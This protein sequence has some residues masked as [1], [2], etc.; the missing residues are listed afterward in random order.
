[1]KQRLEDKLDGDANNQVAKSYQSFHCPV[2]G[3]LYYSGSERHFSSKRFLNQHIAKVHA[4]KKYTCL[5]CQKGFGDDWWRRYHEKSCGQVWKCSC[6]VQY[7]SRETL[8]TH[9]RRMRHELPANVQSSKQSSKRKKSNTISVQPVIVPVV[10]MISAPV[11]NQ[12]NYPTSQISNMNKSSSKLRPILPK[13]SSLQTVLTVPAVPSVESSELCINNSNQSKISDSIDSTRARCT[14]AARKSPS[15]FPCREGF[16]GS[17]DILGSATTTLNVGQS[18]CDRTATETQT[19]EDIP[20]LNL[21]DNI[22]S[23]KNKESRGSQCSG[24]IR[25]RSVRIESIETQTMESALNKIKR[26]S[27]L[28]RSRRKSVAITTDPEIPESVLSKNCNDAWNRHKY[29][30][31]TQTADE[32]SSCKVFCDMETI[33]DDLFSFDW[34]EKM[35]RETKCSTLD[36]VASLSS[37]SVDS[38][39]QNNGIDEIPILDMFSNADSLPFHAE[40]IPS[41]AS[42]IMAGQESCG[43]LQPQGEPV[44]SELST[45]FPSCLASGK[46]LADKAEIPPLSDIQ[47]QTVAP[48]DF[49]YS[50]ILSNME[51]QTTGDFFF[52]DLEFLDNETQTPWED[53]SNIEDSLPVDQLSI[54]IQTDFSSFSDAVNNDPYQLMME[55]QMQSILQN[56]ATK[57][58]EV[59]HTQTQTQSHMESPELT[60]SASQTLD[61]VTDLLFS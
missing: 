57:S 44:N 28:H 18:L 36:M 27:S 33:T 45:V 39:P 17:L 5:K 7:L 9:A 2:S 3:C 4:E 50:N 31:S 23:V 30:A 26:K 20:R 47:T 46:A 42:E 1:M 29:S 8:M 25:K 51:T 15:D 59:I 38:L 61:E 54:E 10:V 22:D 34:P 35:S 40:S 60:S 32:F 56:C 58:S 11:Y 52:S 48:A 14:S 19:N 24:R 49:D 16:S 43:D 41:S 37:S 53:I 55:I 13:T 12:V 21:M 6:G